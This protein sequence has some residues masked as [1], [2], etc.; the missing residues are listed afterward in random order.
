[1]NALGLVR[2][3]KRTL[4]PSVYDCHLPPQGG[5]GEKRWRSLR[6]DALGLVRANKRTLLPSVYDCHLPPQ[7]G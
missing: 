3:N 2:A 7:G 4:L 5:Y 6:M 1:M